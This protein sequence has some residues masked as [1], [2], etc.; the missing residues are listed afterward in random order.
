MYK[1]VAST[2]LSGKNEVYATGE[3]R[4]KV[5]TG[6]VKGINGFIREFL[7]RVTEYLLL[8][9]KALLLQRR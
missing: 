5:L 1:D 6:H 9:R 4:E 8:E 2:F 7:E 3:I